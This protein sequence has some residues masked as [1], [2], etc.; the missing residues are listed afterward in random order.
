M[1]LH[2][3]YE[4]LNAIEFNTNYEMLVCNCTCPRFAYDGL[5]CQRLTVPMARDEE[6]QLQPTNWEEAFLTIQRK[7]RGDAVGSIL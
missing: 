3:W 6:G 7:V 2:V 5:K 4:Y 1:V